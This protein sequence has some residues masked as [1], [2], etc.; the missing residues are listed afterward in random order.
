LARGGKEKTL[1]DLTERKDAK[2]FWKKEEED[3][4]TLKNEHVL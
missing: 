4:S 1:K 3:S 2:S